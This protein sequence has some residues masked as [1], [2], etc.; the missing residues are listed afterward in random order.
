MHPVANMVEIPTDKLCEAME[1]CAIPGF[2]G[3]FTGHIRVLPTAANE[4]EFRFEK[5]TTVQ[6]N[7]PDEP[8]MPHV[9]NARVAKVRRVLSENAERFRLG[10][11]LS[12]VFGT[13]V[14]GELRRF[15]VFEVE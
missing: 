6:I 15:E 9:T 7:K 13:F 1:R 12:R 2:T 11:K 3:D 8:A 14:D 5:K 4:V 10:T